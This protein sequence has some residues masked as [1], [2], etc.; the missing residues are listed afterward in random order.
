M[1]PTTDTEKNLAEAL[2]QV[3]RVER[4]SVDNDF[5]DDLG[6]NSLLMAHFCT[7]VRKREDLPSVSMKD[8]YLNPTIRD[9]AAALPDAVTAPAPSQLEASGE[10]APRA[11][12]LQYILCGS[13]QLLLFV[14][15]ICLLGLVLGAGFEWVSAGIGLVD[16]CVR[17]LAFGAGTF[18]GL[19]TGPILLKW[20]LIGRW[21]PQEIPIWS[22]AYLRFWTV[23]TLVR[24]NPMARFAGSP[25][26]VLYLRALGARIGPGV[27]IFSRNM[28]VCTDLLAIGEGTVI[29][30]DC[31]LNCYRARAGLIQTGRVTLG[32]NVLIGEKSVIDIDTSMGD[33][34]QLGH[35]SCLRASETV[36]PGQRW[37]GS[38]AQQTDVD[39]RSV[40]SARCGAL[41]RASFGAV[42]LLN[43]M[44][45]SGLAI[46][47]LFGYLPTLPLVRTCVGVWG[48]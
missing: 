30:K 1:A 32:M 35:A 26:Y 15:S 47:V 36:P 6:A 2:A 14:G 45:F 8:V 21:K 41:R 19:C 18:A 5:F 20:I 23:K 13:I 16:T 44:I 3:L 27:V 33:G 24:A 38:P 4:V 39:Y 29:R 9:L 40:D 25:L 31:Y 7:L 43:A 28:P 34:A 17:S 42:Q 12:T 37:H 11:S 22:L 46:S 10:A 48:L